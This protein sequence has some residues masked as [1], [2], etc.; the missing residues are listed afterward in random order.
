MGCNASA[1]KGAGPANGSDAGPPSNVI[2]PAVN[3][4]G[5]PA[6][7]IDPAVKG[8]AAQPLERSHFNLLVSA[9]DGWPLHGKFFPLG[10]DSKVK[11]DWNLFWQQLSVQKKALEAAAASPA[12]RGTELN[13]LET[14]QDICDNFC[15]HVHTTVFGQACARSWARMLLSLVVENA[16]SC[17][18]LMLLGVRGG[19]ACD[20]ECAFVRIV[21]LELGFKEE[22]YDVG[23]GCPFNM[24]CQWT[25]PRQGAPSYSVGL[26]QFKELKQA[27][28]MHM[29]FAP[30]SGY[31]CAPLLQRY[32]VISCAEEWPAVDGVAMRINTKET[33]QNHPNG[34][35]VNDKLNSMVATALGIAK[36][37]AAAKGFRPLSSDGFPAMPWHSDPKDRAAA[38][39]YF[40]VANE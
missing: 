2:D 35:T 19:P 5:P 34:M 28:S 6:A 32:A 15:T 38:C 1:A 9:P 30:C 33:D 18:A 29:T 40:D 16:S 12:P 21:L 26:R 25:L 22:Q 10:P 37:R 27:E 4:T 39:A 13:A 36:E 14:V 23:E 7:G 17:E 3:G 8:A 31:T 11:G 24:S 20:E